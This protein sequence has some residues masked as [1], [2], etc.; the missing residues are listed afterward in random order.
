MIGLGG[1]TEQFDGCFNGFVAVEL[2][3]TRSTRF[4]PLNKDGSYL[5]ING[6]D[7][8]F[9]FFI[10]IPIKLCFLKGTLAWDSDFDENEKNRK[11][12]AENEE[13]SSE[14]NSDSD[15]TSKKEFWKKKKMVF[16]WKRTV[17]WVK[18][19]GFLL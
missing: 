13:E 17:F 2:S 18:M 4:Y 12:T 10:K 14:F 5:N 3:T 19:S 9:L 8:A 6:I 15:E 16:E 1:V 11:K 7:F